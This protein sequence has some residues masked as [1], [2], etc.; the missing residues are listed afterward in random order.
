[1]LLSSVR[2][3]KYTILTVW[4]IHESRKL[5]GRFPEHPA[6]LNDV[7]YLFK[8]K[9]VVS[10]STREGL[11]TVHVWDLRLDSV[12]EV[13]EFS[14][15]SLLHMDTYKDVLV[16]FQI[17]WKTNPPVV[18]QTRWRLMTR[19]LLETKRF[20]LSLPGYTI[21]AVNKGKIL[22]RPGFCRHILCHKTIAELLVAID[23]TIMY[24]HLIYDQAVDKLS[25]RW[26]E[27]PRAFRKPSNIIDRII[28]PTPNLVY[29][30]HEGS[31]N[32]SVLDVTKGTTLF[33]KHW[34]DGRL[35][36]SQ[37]AR[38]IWFAATPVEKR[39]GTGIRPFGDKEVFGLAGYGGV[40]L[41]FFDPEFAPDCPHWDKG[42]W[43]RH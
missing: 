43:K 11:W 16:T 18:R 41:W 19:E 13:G 39:D 32:P 42:V 27:Y 2:G 17:N 30:W 26:V 7:F 15:L 29:Y 4:D 20:F 22:P 23:N 8:D 10:Y 36:G 38:R 24:L 6:D 31:G 35:I 40:E 5:V 25:A 33:P 14:D 12:R 37:S 34:V 28:L 21:H 1:M 9:L 3:E